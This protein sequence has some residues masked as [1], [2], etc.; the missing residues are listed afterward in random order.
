M[1]SIELPN[2]P[3]LREHIF[4]IRLPEEFEKTALEVFHIQY[5]NNVIYRT[6]CRQLH[7]TPQSVQQI[8]EI[9]FLP[10]S[11]FKTHKIQCGVSHPD[12]IF[13]SS[14]TTGMQVSRHHVKDISL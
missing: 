13:E 4:N 2:I 3:L 8:S 7:K 10:I 6:F 9:P 12:I 14:G 11:F 5:E 1:M